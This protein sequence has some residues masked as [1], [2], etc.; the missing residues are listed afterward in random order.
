LLAAGV[1]SRIVFAGQYEFPSMLLLSIQYFLVG[2][3]SRLV[4]SRL[5]PLP[6]SATLLLLAACPLVAYTRSLEMGLW[7]LFAIFILQESGLL[8]TPSRG[9]AFLQYVLGTNPVIRNLGTFSYSTYLI[10]LPVIAIVV[11]F[12]DTWRPIRQQTDIVIA[13]A[14][15]LAVVLIVSPL[16]YYLVEKPFIDIG[17]RKR[18]A[19]GDDARIASAVSTRAP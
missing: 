9:F 18:A 6:V 3:V 2:I 5:Q 1:A 14:L 12:Y 19:R 7:A 17:K 15:A 4:L 10:H 13:T 8:A 11:H 16:A